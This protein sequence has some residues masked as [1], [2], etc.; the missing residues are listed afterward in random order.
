[1]EPFTKLLGGGKP[2]DMQKEENKQRQ[3]A[4][5]KLNRRLL[6]SQGR[7]STITTSLMGL[8]GGQQ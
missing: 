4:A 1:M 7:A 2:V 3:A 5:E 8:P 6:S